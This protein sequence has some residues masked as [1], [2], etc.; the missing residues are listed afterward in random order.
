LLLRICFECRLRRTGR[1]AG[2]AGGLIRKPG[3]P[4]TPYLDQPLHRDG[5]VLGADQLLHDGCLGDV[6][7]R[8]C[9]RIVGADEPEE[10]RHDSCA[11]SRQPVRVLRPGARTGL[12][13]CCPRNQRE[14]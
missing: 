14:F 11:P 5:P 6:W 10:A 13:C 1:G 8:A 12:L 2:P 3:G 4:S 7:V 9:L